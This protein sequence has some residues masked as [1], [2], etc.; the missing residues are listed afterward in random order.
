MNK[1]LALLMRNLLILMMLVSTSLL[2]GCVNPEDGSV[3]ASPSTSVVPPNHAPSIL[4]DHAYT[5]DPSVNYSSSFNQSLP[6]SLTMINYTTIVV[7]HAVV[8][9]DGDNLTMG[10][11]VD[12]DGHIDVS[13]SQ[14]SGYTNVSIP[15]SLWNPH[16]MSNTSYRISF[17]FIALDE[18]G[19]GSSAFVDSGISI[20]PLRWWHDDAYTPNYALYQF[21]GEDDTGNPGTDTT[22]YLIRITMDQ[23]NDIGWSAISVKIEVNGGVPQTCDNP[24][25]DGTGPCVLEEFG[26][27]ITNTVLS[28]GDGFRIKENGQDLCNTACTI[29]VTI[30]DTRE[31]RVLYTIN[32]VAAE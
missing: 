11:D 12:L 7:Y 19:H 22:D 29:D 24:G 17:A 14:H 21:T 5:D 15:T 9:I 1:K 32:N 28:A 20:S 27:D 18:H 8:D 2:A 26:T 23:G 25:I 13:V 4:L 6:I 10:Y 30:T 3:S 16:P 31:G